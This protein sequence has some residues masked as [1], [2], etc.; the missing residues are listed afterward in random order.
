MTKSLS[1]GNLKP[2]LNTC[3]NN[4]LEPE[5]ILKELKEVQERLLEL[6]A[7]TA[8]QLVK[9]IV[10]QGIFEI[11]LCRLEQHD[12]GLVLDV[13]QE[14]LP[15][16]KLNPYPEAPLWMPGLLNLR[17]VMVP[18]IDVQARIGRYSRE[19]QLGDVIV[20]CNSVGRRFGLVFDQVSTVHQADSSSIQP[21]EA[22]MP[23]TPYVLGMLSILKRSILLLSLDPLLATSDI[24]EELI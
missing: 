13:V 3:R 11:V 5:Q 7:N 17:G 2:I 18:V 22:H 20:V 8:Q 6:H 1:R 14:V 16:C 23:Y 15:M 24:P 21:V 19:C 9:E 10:P 12:M 4:T